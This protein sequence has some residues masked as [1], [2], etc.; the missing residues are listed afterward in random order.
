[1]VASEYEVGVRA[2]VKSQAGA[3][4]ALAV[5]RGRSDATGWIGPACHF[6]DPFLLSVCARSL[7]VAGDAHFKG[8]SGFTV[9]GVFDL[10]TI[11]NT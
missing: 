6:D 10:G 11:P 5:S 8:G 7:C 9:A 1:M 2:P 3:P 4:S